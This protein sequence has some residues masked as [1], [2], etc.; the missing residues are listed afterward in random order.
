MVKDSLIREVKEFLSL[1]PDKTKDI[2]SDNT[3]GLNPRKI[4][5]NKA[6]AKVAGSG[7]NRS[8]NELR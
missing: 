2:T 4:R 5:L 1:F 8:V 3:A 7:K 6:K